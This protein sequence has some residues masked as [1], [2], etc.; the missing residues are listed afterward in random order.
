MTI[1]ARRCAPPAL[2]MLAIAGLVAGCG[3]GGDSAAAPAT[4]PATTTAPDPRAGYFTQQESD[5]F[6]PPL[7]KLNAA[8]ARYDRQVQAC[9]R[10]AQRLFNAG[11]PPR[12]A[13]RCHLQLIGALRDA[14]RD[15]TRAA[16]GIDGDFRPQCT[17]QLRRF[18]ASS[19]A[20]Q[21]AWEKNLDDWNAYARGDHAATLRI[22]TDGDRAQA[23]T[24]AV[25]AGDSAIVK[26]SRACY[27]KADLDQAAAAATTTTTTTTGT[28]K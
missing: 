20:M 4:T 10:E 19:V 15:V 27:T 22:P 18:V 5:A 12:V 1:R 24:R 17:R 14:S 11:R 21:A 13:I 25:L 8:A 2:L 16:R 3:G 23:R 9:D 28:T 7:A 26:L 6:N